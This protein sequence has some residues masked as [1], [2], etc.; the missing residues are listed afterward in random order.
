MQLSDIGE[1]NG[2][3][4]CLTN[5]E[6]CCSSTVG[7]HHG[8]WHFLGRRTDSTSGIFFTQGSSALLLSRRSNTVGPTGIYT[9]GVPDANS[10]YKFLYVGIYGPEASEGR[11]CGFVWSFLMSSLS[12]SLTVSLSYDR[13]SH[14]LTCVSS[15]GPVTTVTWRR[16]GEAISPESS[17]HHRM[18]Q[19]LRESTY[20]NF[21]AITSSFFED[22]VGPFSCTVDNARGNATSQAVT[23]ERESKW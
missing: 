20:H 12:G 15:G 13:A 7:G 21:L 4:L 8:F 18:G 1:G 9:C 11:L 6:R 16:N 2:S 10:L 23:T 19:A 14:T 22:F 5:L 17:S 3:L